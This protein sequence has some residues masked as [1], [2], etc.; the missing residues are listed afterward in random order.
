M[1]KPTWKELDNENEWLFKR[2]ERLAAENETLTQEASELFSTISNVLTKLDGD[3]SAQ[4]HNYTVARKRLRAI[5][6]KWG[7]R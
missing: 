3:D 6:K 2:L 7:L 4:I 1:K 5:A